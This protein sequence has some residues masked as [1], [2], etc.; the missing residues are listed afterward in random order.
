MKAKA[1]RAGRLAAP[2]PRGERSAHQLADAKV[3]DRRGDIQPPECDQGSKFPDTRRM[4]LGWIAEGRKPAF[5]RCCA[6]P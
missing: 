6:A 5:P 1:V 4:R 2:R 3:A